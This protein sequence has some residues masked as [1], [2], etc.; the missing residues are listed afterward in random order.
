MVDFAAMLKTP[1]AEIKAPP[2][3]PVGTYQ[4]KVGTYKTLTKTIQGEEKGIFSFNFSILN[5]MEDVDPEAIEIFGGTDALKKYKLKHDIFVGD[6]DNL[7]NIAKF[8]TEICRVEQ[9]D[10]MSFEE[11]LAETNG[12]TVIISVQH[13]ARTKGEGF[14]AIIDK[15]LADE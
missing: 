4:V 9:T 12:T 13:K 10:E 1:V 14:M 3:L 8:A 5:A 2:T 11:L 7:S 15:V 6:N